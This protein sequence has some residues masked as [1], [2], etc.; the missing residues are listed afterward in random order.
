MQQEFDFDTVPSKIF[1]DSVS[2]RI[3]NGVLHLAIRS[4]QS[5]SC[6]LLPLPLAKIVGKAIG[7]QVEEIEQKNNITF[8]D[9]LPNEPMLSPWTSQNPNDDSRQKK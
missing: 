6:Y 8:D 9:R 5:V 3:I 4:G 2:I 7:K 1:V